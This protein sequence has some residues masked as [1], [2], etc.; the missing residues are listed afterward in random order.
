MFSKRGVL[1][2]LAVW[3]AAMLTYEYY[4]TIEDPGMD[5]RVEL[6]HKIACCCRT[7][8]RDWPG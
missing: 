8:V 3:L 1:C 4:L 2:W 6:H 7:W 5:A